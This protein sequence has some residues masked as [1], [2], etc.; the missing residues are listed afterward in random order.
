MG[1]AW[2]IGALD[3]LER[4]GGLRPAE[5]AEILGTSV[6][7][8]VAVMVAAGV[9]TEAMAAYAVGESDGALEP[10]HDATAVRLTRLPLSPRPGSL[11]MALRARG[12]AGRLTGLLP[13]GVVS[14]EGIASLVHR[15]VG[16]RW[17][18][19]LIRIVACEY[20]SGDRV[21]L[22]PGREPACPPAAA[23][24]ASCAIPGFYAPVAIGGRDFV[25]GGIHSHSNLDLLAGSQ[26][27]AVIAVNPMSAGAWV[28]GGGLRE[29]AAALRRRRSAARLEAEAQ[30]L[31][32]GGVQVLV[33]EPA[34]SDIA[35][36]GSN[37]MARDR[38][39]EVIEAGRASTERALRRLGRKRLRLLGLTP[40]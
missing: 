22:G 39:G 31:R 24:A 38:R 11:S 25:D 26:L 12:G 8:L 18:E 2:M 17:P 4:H 10:H 7:S 29:R 13:R 30:L 36:M 27:D 21:E 32:S 34:F 37:M 28:G 6:G 1:A 23:V 35:A 14:T 3:A 33:L 9:P 16:E 15:V 5:T 40:G 20:A 19:G